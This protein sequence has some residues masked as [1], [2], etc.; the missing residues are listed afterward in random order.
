[1]TLKGHTGSTQFG[2]FSPTGSAYVDVVLADDPVAYYRLA[3]LTDSSGNGLTLSSGG[4]VTDVASLLVSDP[5]NGAKRFLTDA[6]SDVLS[7][8][9]D[10]LLRI[11]SASTIEAWVKPAFIDRF[12]GVQ[13]DHTYE[14]SIRGS[15]GRFRAEFWTSGGF[16]DA[17]STTVAVVGSTYH[18]VGTFDGSRTRLYVNGA[19]EATSAAIVGTPN[20]SANPFCLG[21]DPGRTGGW[22]GVIDEVAVYQTVLTPERILT[23]YNAGIGL[24]GEGLENVAA[25]VVSGATAIGSELTC[26]TGAWSLTGLSFAYQW[27]RSSTTT[28]TR[29]TALSRYGDATTRPTGCSWT[30]TARRWRSSRFPATTGSLSCGWSGAATSGGL[31]PTKTSRRGCQ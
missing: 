16:W 6:S 23:H 1:M 17:D 13:K 11:G 20:N 18:I 14:L 2:V 28:A 5:V 10:P 12:R 21:A 29:S 3:D 26:S 9:D 25:P 15:D 30:R 8:A 27:K 19:L 22:W 7:H 24:P 4:T 31:S